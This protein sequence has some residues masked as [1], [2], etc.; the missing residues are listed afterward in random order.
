MLEGALSLL[1]L[2]WAL[3]PLSV[4]LSLQVVVEGCNPRDIAH[5][6]QDVPAF[7]RDLRIET[8]CCLRIDSD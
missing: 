5:C 1:E 7:R 6:Y 3:G 8:D 2:E 4:A